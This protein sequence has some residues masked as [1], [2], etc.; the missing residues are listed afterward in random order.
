[1]AGARVFER[2]DPERAARATPQVRLRAQRR[3]RLPMRSSSSCRRRASANLSRR[4]RIECSACAA[5][6]LR[7]LESRAVAHTA[8]HDCQG[9]FHIVR[10][11]A[12]GGPSFL[13]YPRQWLVRH[14]CA[15]AQVPY[16]AF[17]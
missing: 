17:C 4:L 9:A 13:R 16:R 5:G 1:V 12:R 10:S 6:A 7:H 2:T 3:G 15:P 8:H 14:P 11:R